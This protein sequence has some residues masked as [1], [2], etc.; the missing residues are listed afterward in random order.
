MTD[1]S[2]G[3]GATFSLVAAAPATYDEAGYEALTFVEV[4]K[5]VDIGDIPSRVYQVVEQ[6]YLKTAGTDKAKGGYN[7]GSQTIRATIDDS[8][9]GQALLDTATNATGAYSIKLSHPVLGDIYAR[10]LVTGGPKT[11]GDNN[12]PAT[13]SITIEYKQASATADGVV[14][15][16][17]A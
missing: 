11:W 2:T 6:Q 12:T 13:R 16:A 17:A 10:A 15:V 14:A 3:A 9:A 1:F 5:L 7:L 4:G 8:D